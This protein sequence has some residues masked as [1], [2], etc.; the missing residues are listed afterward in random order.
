MPSMKLIFDNQAA[1]HI[2][3]NPVCHERTKHIKINYHFVR[4]KR[5][6]S[7]IVNE[8]VNSNNQLADVFTKALRRPRIELICNKLGAYDI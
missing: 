7:V 5:V 8:F 3:S 4:E 6:E 2:T 1:L